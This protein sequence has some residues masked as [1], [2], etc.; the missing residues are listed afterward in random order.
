MVRSLHIMGVKMKRLSVTLLLIG[1]LLLAGCAANDPGYVYLVNPVPIAMNWQGPYD[2]L[3]TYRVNDTVGYNNSSYI[4]I[5]ASTGNLPTDTTYWDLLALE[6]GPGSNGI[7]GVSIIWHGVYDAG[8]SYDAYDGVSYLGSC[9]ICILASL[10]NLPTDPTY[11]DLLASKGS[12]GSNGVDG[13]DGIDGADGLSIVWH[14]PWDSGHAY[15]IN[16]AVSNSGSSYISIQAGTNHAVSDG[17]FWQLL[18]SIGSTGAAGPN[19]ITSATNTDLTGLLKGN[20][21]IVSAVTAPTGAVVGTTDTQELDSKTLDSSVGKGT[22]TASG[23]WELPAVTLGGAV[24]LGEVSVLLDAAISADGK[25]SGIAEAGTAGATLAFGDLVYFQTADSRWE[26]TDANSTTTSNLKLGICILAAAN[27]GSA[28][29]IL[30]WGKV[31]A[32]DKFPTLT[33]GAP[34]FISEA[35]G[36]IVTTAPATAA[37]IVRIIGYGNTGDELFFC[38]SNNW[39]QLT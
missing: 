24:Q 12:D 28:T 3:V 34:V 29:M 11:W 17:A 37:A 1:I 20:G 15:I 39:I 35:A 19:T 38:P 16:D 13:I 10:N 18:A 30:L 36:L 6:G 2:P 9:Y 7:D 4:C 32:A 23:T 27:D 21:S 22:W 14:G 25:W 5:L 8:H 31:N 33:I 26:L